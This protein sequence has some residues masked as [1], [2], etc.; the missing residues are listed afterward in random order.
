MNHYFDNYKSFRGLGTTLVEMYI[1]GYTFTIFAVEA[2][3][4][5]TYASQAGVTWGLKAV[6]R[7]GN[8]YFCWFNDK[9]EPVDE[10]NS[11]LQSRAIDN[12]LRRLT[13]RTRTYR[14]IWH[15]TRTRNN[16][17][18]HDYDTEEEAVKKARQ[19]AGNP[20]SNDIKVYH[21]EHWNEVREGVVWSC[22]SVLA[23]IQW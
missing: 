11:I 23:T 18:S 20:F 16:R 1:P 4:F 17:Y 5:D 3:P 12:V 10:M 9:G 7:H 2:D 21:W 8:E 22:G 13:R 14:V 15:T 6:G 19:V